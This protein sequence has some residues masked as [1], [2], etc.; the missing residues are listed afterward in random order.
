MAIW[1]D[2]DKVTDES[3]FD[4]APLRFKYSIHPYSDSL[5]SC[6]KSHPPMKAAALYGSS[7]WPGASGWAC[8]KS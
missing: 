5:Q 1:F 7:P 4:T 3:F 6:M 8:P 2:L